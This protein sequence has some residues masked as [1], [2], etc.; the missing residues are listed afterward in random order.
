MSLYAAA[1][2]LAYAVATVWV[3]DRHLSHARWVIRHPNLGLYAW[4]AVAMACLASV[5]G[6][7]L[8]L[9]HDVLERPLMWALHADKTALHLLYAGDR[10]VSGLWNGA[11]ALPLTALAASAVVMLTRSLAARR[12][13]ALIAMLS[14]PP[15]MSDSS[16]QDDVV[17]LDH[18]V[19]SVHCLPGRRGRG[20]IV[21][22]QATLQTLTADELAAAL[23]HERGHLRL[24]HHRMVLT[25]ESMGSA[26]RWLPGMSSYPSQV[27]RLVE[28]AADDEASRRCGERTVASALLAMC[29]FHEADPSPGLPFSG[30][31][32]AGRI[33]RLVERD[34]RDRGTRRPGRHAP[35]KALFSLLWLIPPAV[36]LLPAA[37]LAGSAH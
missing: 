4:H 17:V 1:L 33:Q 21:L 18:H 15:V 28:L 9:A 26:F 22:T 11:V 32:V 24:R 37:T 13:R 3:A 6:V 25:A 30:V 31:E 10:E 36:V 35:I 2:L 7:C 12:Q 5:T 20:M 19:P 27:R 34:G 16:V 29:C 14:G 23:E 8:L